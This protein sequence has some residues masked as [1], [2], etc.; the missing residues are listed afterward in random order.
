LR[1]AKLC[2]EGTSA[3]SK[4]NENPVK[5]SYVALWS[6]Y[7]DLLKAR[8]DNSTSYRATLLN[9]SNQIL[10]HYF[11]QLCGYTRDAVRKA[12]VDKRNETIDGDVQ[13]PKYLLALSMLDSITSD[14]RRAP[15]SAYFSGGAVDVEQYMESFKLIFD[16]MKPEQH[17][18][19]MMK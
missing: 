13:R 14:S 11:I 10:E 3:A 18:E 15:D 19:K 7:K 9:N 12:V 16:A 17:Y 4:V 1:P 2:V 6:E 8:I 5:S